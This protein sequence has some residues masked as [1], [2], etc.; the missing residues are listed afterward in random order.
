MTQ[1]IWAGAQELAAGYV[2][3]D[4]NGT[5]LTEFETLLAHSFHLQVEVYMLQVAFHQVPQ[6]LEQVTPPPA[7]QARLLETFLQAIR[8]VSEVIDIAAPSN[9]LQGLGDC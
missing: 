1:T 4:L 2:L 3:G 8:E 6:G 5:E 9:Q 7:L